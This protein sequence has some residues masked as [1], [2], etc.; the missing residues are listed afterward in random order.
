MKCDNCGTEVYDV[1]T[2]RERINSLYKIHNTV[3]WAKQRLVVLSDMLDKDQPHVSFPPKTE[4]IREQVIKI[5]SGLKTVS[6]YEKLKD[7]PMGSNDSRESHLL[8][9]KQDSKIRK[10]E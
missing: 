2:T 4:W 10:K 5:N 7:S 1:Y 3:V 8:D 9:S 6:D